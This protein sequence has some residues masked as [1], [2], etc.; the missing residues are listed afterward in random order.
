MKLF[1]RCKNHL[2]NKK[3]VV[4]ICMSAIIATSSVNPLLFSAQEVQGK[5]LANTSDFDLDKKDIKKLQNQAV[6]DDC[7]ICVEDKNGNMQYEVNTDGTVYEKNDKEEVIEITKVDGQKE[8]V[9]FDEIDEATEELSAETKVDTESLY[10]MLGSSRKS[11]KSKK[12]TQNN[13]YVRGVRLNNFISDKKFQFNKEWTEQKIQSFLKKKGSILK[14]EIKVYA[15]KSRNKIYYTG[16]KIKPAKLI[17]EACKK[18]NINPQIILVTL[19]KENILITKKSIKAKSDTCCFAL[20]YGHTSSGRKY[21][22]SGIDKQIKGACQS[23]RKKFNKAPK[24]KKVMKLYCG[25]TSYP[26]KIR[27]ENRATWVMFTY[28]PHYEG[29]YLYYVIAKGWG[30]KLK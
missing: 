1:G 17:Y 2:L 8:E 24:K 4:G 19:Q 30:W 20:R 23:M 13:Y 10:Q 14:K 26:T 21:R 6:K 27:I 29:N 15:E 11:K 7:V 22:L 16:R 9:S 12:A 5:D 25:G 3:T 28:T 18:S